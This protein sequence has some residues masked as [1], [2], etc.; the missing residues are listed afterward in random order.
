MFN[1]FITIANTE[2]IHG[3]FKGIVPRLIRKPI[4]TA[5]SWGIYELFNI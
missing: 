2:G 1:A 4:N 5:I 3:Y